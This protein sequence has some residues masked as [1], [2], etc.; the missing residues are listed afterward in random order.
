MRDENAKALLKTL[1]VELKV[2]EPRSE[3]RCGSVLGSSNRPE[4]SAL[5]RGVDLVASH[6]PRPLPGG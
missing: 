4:L 2:Q 5:S 6:E 3:E 1:P